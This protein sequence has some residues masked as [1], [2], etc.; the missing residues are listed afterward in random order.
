ML[1]D[2][3]DEGTAA[4]EAAHVAFLATLRAQQQQQKCSRLAK[5]AAAV[6]RFAR[7][8]LRGCLEVARAAGV[9]VAVIGILGVG[10]AADAV[11]NG[12]DV[13]TAKVLKQGRDEVRGGWRAYS[14]TTRSDP[15]SKSAQG[16]KECATNIQPGSF[17]EF[18]SAVVH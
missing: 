9:G 8:P 5:S 1:L 16:Q 13:V 7:D 6:A 3:G 2:G 14:K 18:S 15:S 17:S 4:Y 10:K 12:L 11:S